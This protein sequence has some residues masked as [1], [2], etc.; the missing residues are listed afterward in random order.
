MED[1]TPISDLILQRIGGE[2]R[3]NLWEF[4][5]Q[6]GVSPAQFENYQRTNYRGAEVTS[7]GTVQMILDWNEGVSPL[8]QRQKLKDALRNAGLIRIQVLYVP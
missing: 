1:N 2:I 3:T 4:A 6:L 5:D 7:D 8:E